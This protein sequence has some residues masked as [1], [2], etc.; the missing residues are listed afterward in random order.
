[1]RKL[2]YIFYPFCLWWDGFTYFAHMEGQ[3]VMTRVSGEKWQPYDFSQDMI[4]KL[5][6]YIR[7]E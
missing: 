4:P 7:G 1:M 2:L 3:I 5:K 6:K